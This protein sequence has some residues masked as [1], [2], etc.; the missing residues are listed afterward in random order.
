V[1]R[2]AFACFG[3]RGAWITAIAAVLSG[4]GGAPAART[5]FLQSVDLVNMTD[6]MAESFS[7]NDAITRR[8]PSDPPWIV[9]F[10]KIENQ[11]NQIIPEREKWLYIG[12][13]RA[14]LAESDVAKAHHIIWIIPPEE[15]PMIAQELGVSNEPYG[16]RMH[17]THQL[18]GKFGT[19]TNTSGKGRSDLYV[20]GYQLIDL[21]DGRIVW[22]GTWEVKRAISGKTYD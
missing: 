6:R 5:T 13:L 19:L 22:E 16:L 9:S 8:S 10:S 20:C 11:T 21:R 18:T 15:W 17:P 7:H 4:C 2:A 12:R 14:L 1:S 3:A